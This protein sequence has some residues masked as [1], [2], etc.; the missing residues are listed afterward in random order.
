[1]QRIGQVAYKLALPPSS[2]I[3][4]VF[5]VSCL[6]LKLGQH[7]TPLSTLPLVD[8]NGEIKPEPKVVISR[9]MI[10]RKGQAITEVLICWK[11]AEDD[12]WETLSHSS[13]AIPPPCTQGALKM[14]NLLWAW[15]R[16]IC[17][18]SSMVEITDV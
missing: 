9:H 11:G 1:M 10:K 14:G 12:S 18:C 17:R 8:S 15:H 4:P 3:H 7:I 5:H 6:K 16:R 2:R 13:R